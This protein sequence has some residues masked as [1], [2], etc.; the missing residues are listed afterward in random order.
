MALLKERLALVQWN[1]SYTDPM[2]PA[3]VQWNLSYTDPMGPA[4]VQWNL[5]YTDPTEPALVQWNLSYTDPFFI[6]TTLDK[7][8]HSS[9]VTYNCVSIIL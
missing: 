5:G 8:G 2:G 1:L 9:T 6:L 3:L 7:R 4:L